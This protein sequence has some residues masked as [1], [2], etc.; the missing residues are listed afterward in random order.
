MHL[1]TYTAAMDAWDESVGDCTCAHAEV[2]PEGQGPLAE[3]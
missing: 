3:T 2:P 1:V